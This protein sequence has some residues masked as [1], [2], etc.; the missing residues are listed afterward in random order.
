V[1]LLQLGEFVGANRR[2]VRLLRA[3][4]VRVQANRRLAAARE[5][6]NGKLR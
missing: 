3:C 6:K 4:H 2:A 5:K 1:L